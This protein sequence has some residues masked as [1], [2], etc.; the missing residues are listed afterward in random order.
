M[1]PQSNVIGV[2]GGVAELTERAA[3]GVVVESEDAPALAN[4]ILDLARRSRHE[5]AAMGARGRSFYQRA[6]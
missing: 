3:A 5:L 1:K 6:S 4:A 2:R